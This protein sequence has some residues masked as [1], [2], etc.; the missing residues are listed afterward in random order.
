M[1]ARRARAFRT[2]FP[3]SFST[4]LVRSDDAAIAGGRYQIR[5]GGGREQP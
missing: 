2:V 4:Y 3:S 1:T 5:T